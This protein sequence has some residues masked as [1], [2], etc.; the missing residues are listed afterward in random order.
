MMKSQSPFD[1]W[2]A[3]S[4]LFPF[5]ATG[6]PSGPV[7]LC[8]G[9]FPSTSQQGKVAVLYCECRGHGHLSLECQE[10]LQSLPDGF[11]AADDQSRLREQA[12]LLLIESHDPVKVPPLC[13]APSVFG[14]LECCRRWESWTVNRHMDTSSR[15]NAIGTYEG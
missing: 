14:S 6:F 7:P 9:Q 10:L 13:H 8:A 2:R 5:M 4:M 11:P 15:R 12:R 1:C 3:T